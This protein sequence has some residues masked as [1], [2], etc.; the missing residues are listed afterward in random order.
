MQISRIGPFALEEPLD[1]TVRSNVLR[2]VHVERRLNVAVKLLPRSILTRAMGNGTFLEDV[3]KLQKLEHPAIVRLLGGAVEHGQPYLAMELVEGESLRTHLDRRGRLPWEAAVEMADTIC[4]A[5]EQAHSQAIVHQRLTPRRVMLPQKG[6]VKLI[7]FDCAWADRDEVM[8]LH[9]PMEVA[10]YLAP[11]QFRGKPSAL[12][13]ASDMFSLGVILFELLTGELPW[14]ADSPTHLI[15]ARRASPAPRVSSRV[16]DCPV[17]LDI[18]V[19][20]LLVVRRSERF[21]TALETHR[22]LADA[23]RKV[24]GGMGAAQQAWSGQR[25]TL[26]IDTE[27][28]EVRR[29]RRQQLKNQQ[30]K[31][32]TGG[33]FYDRAWFLALCLVALAGAGIWAL[34]PP[35]EEALFA[36]AKPL[37]ESDDP[38]DWRHAKIQYLDSFQERFPDS[39][40][41]EQIEQFEQ[42]LA[43]HRAET[44][45]KNNERL[46]RPA[47]SEA[48]R[49]FAEA[50]RFERFG[51]R[52][53]AWQKY[54]ALVVLFESS[55]DPVDHAFIDLARR[56]IGRIQA[57]SEG[58]TGQTQLVEEKLAQ[59]QTLIDA[60]NPL[61]ARRLLQGIVSLYDGNREL[62]PL[63]KQAREAMRQLDR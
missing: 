42:R 20:G 5:L 6:G 7:G 23:Q 32:P 18:L 28:K 36:K 50:K 21:A 25:G 44:R 38:G 48:E 63:V 1:E 17:W 13:P 51:D 40:Y 52:L 8:G 45:F 41:G 56:Q 60:G 33:A 35:D 12:L 29:L 9:S 27:R 43:M 53:T 15:Q 31:A 54:E 14:P 49:R 58:Q 57:A 62:R 3:K 37:M 16:L 2:G 11:E 61:E 22:A 59:A 47:R 55:Q 24:A 46:G 30:R 10:N 19:S 4:S 39:R 34:L 26:T